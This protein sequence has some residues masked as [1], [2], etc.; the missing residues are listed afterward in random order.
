MRTRHILVVFLISTAAFAVTGKRAATT[1]P[2]YFPDDP[3]ARE[4]ASQDASRAAVWEI[5]ELYEMTYNLFV[6][7]GYKPSGRRAQNVNTI[8]EV[9]DS[10]WFTNRI[11]TRPLTVDEIVRGPIV[12]APPDPSRWVIV[13]EKLSGVHPGITARDGRG[14]TWFLEFDPTYYPEGATGAVLM[15]TKFFWAL[16]YNQVESFLT[17]F[18]PRR[19]DVDPKATIR[20]PNG[21]RTPFTHDDLHSI[22]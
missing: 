13:R 12:G 22:L 7:P 8:D 5:G 14:E 2:R 4:P 21:K 19:T 18:D 17:T 20:R 11:G 10:S 9:P 16:G 1:S 3:I 6:Q 15:A